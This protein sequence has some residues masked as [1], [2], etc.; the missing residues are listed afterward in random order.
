MSASP[1]SKIVEFP[2][3]RTGAER[4]QDEEIA[5]STEFVCEEWGR[6]EATVAF[7]APVTRR[8][9]ALWI[10]PTWARTAS[11]EEMKRRA[12]RIWLIR[13]S[14]WN[15]REFTLIHTRES[16]PAPLLQKAA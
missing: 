5:A 12:T 9:R 4:L 15:P 6:G 3:G 14:L 7:Y 1:G 10:H 13:G 16:E 2:T 11:W 8:G